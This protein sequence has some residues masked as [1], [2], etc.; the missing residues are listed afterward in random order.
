MLQIG[1]K[2]H[3]FNTEPRWATSVEF[4]VKIPWVFDVQSAR[5]ALREL[6][7]GNGKLKRIGRSITTTT[8]VLGHKV[9]I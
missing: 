3:G 6:L 2:T 8:M 5:G 1:I 7:G 4:G 9:Q